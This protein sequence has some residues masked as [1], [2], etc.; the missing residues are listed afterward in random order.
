MKKTKK[1]NKKYSYWLSEEGLTKLT[2][3]ALESLSNAE[4]AE[5]MDIHPSTLYEWQNRFED[6][7]S[8][9][10][11]GKY[12]EMA[13]HKVEC[14][15][16]TTGLASNG[17]V[18][19]ENWFFRGGTRVYRC[20]ICKTFVPL[21]EYI[22]SGYR[23]SSCDR[24]MSREYRSTLQGKRVKKRYAKKYYKDNKDKVY[25]AVYRRHNKIK[26]NIYNYTANQWDKALKYFNYECAYCGCTDEL[27]RE[28]IIPVS[29]G[30]HYIRQNIVPACRACNVSK[31]D[32][33]MERW[34]RQQ[35]FFSEK[36][37]KKIYDWANVDDE[38][39]QIALF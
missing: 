15:K 37:L 7:Y 19:S 39:Q 28:H 24:E 20:S 6:I 38:T 13:L 27:E 12:P 16:V 9:L 29:K 30:G 10:M 25:R 22:P 23:C 4:I 26:N 8:A 2:N 21:N 5:K 3:W 35:E 31:L 36:R 17:K 1:G 32:K 33:D 18:V 14:K 11:H 34:Y